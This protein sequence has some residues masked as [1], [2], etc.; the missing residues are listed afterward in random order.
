M[1]SL[2]KESFEKLKSSSR[3]EIPLKIIYRIFIL[4]WRTLITYA[5]KLFLENKGNNNLNSKKNFKIF[6]SDMY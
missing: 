4:I 3:G 1:V 6:V 2:T 5:I